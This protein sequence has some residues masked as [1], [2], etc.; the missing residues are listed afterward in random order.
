MD[1]LLRSNDGPVFGA[2]GRADARDEKRG[3]EASSVAAILDRARS[4]SVEPSA[5]A[6]GPS[7]EPR[8]PYS[9]QARLGRTPSPLPPAS[10][11]AFPL[12]DPS[13]CRDPP[14]PGPALAARSG[15]PSARAGRQGASALLPRPDSRVAA[16]RPRVRGA[17]P[18]PRLAGLGAMGAQRAGKRLSAVGV[19]GTTTVMPSPGA[20]FRIVASVHPKA[21]VCWCLAR[22]KPLWKRWIWWRKSPQDPRLQLPFSVRFQ[23]SMKRV[24]L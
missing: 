22:G 10:S 12:R 23:G 11:A 13:A 7:L 16:R 5:A 6:A 9:R 24:R 1:Q 21:P 14:G 4:A 8:I 15:L 17:R 18:P 20:P 2:R 3:G 19:G